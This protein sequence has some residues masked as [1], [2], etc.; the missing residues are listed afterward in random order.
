MQQIHQWQDN[1]SDEKNITKQHATKLKFHRRI[2]IC[3]KKIM[4]SSK[5]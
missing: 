5:E 4:K 2:K 1:V 3:R